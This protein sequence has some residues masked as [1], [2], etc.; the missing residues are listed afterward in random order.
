MPRDWFDPLPHKALDDAIEQG[1]LFCNILAA[2]RSTR[3]TEWSVARAENEAEGAM[4]DIL[5]W[6]LGLAFA[7][8]LVLVG[9][10]DPDEGAMGLRN[11]ARTL[12][13]LRRADANDPQA[14]LRRGSAVGR[15]DLRE[16]RLQG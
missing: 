4:I 7:V 9:G 5:F 11:V 6:V 10:T 2:S 12:P 1:A 15:M 16:V 13:A 3:A 14:G 8:C